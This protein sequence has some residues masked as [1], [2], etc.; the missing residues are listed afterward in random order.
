MIERMFQRSTARPGDTGLVNGMVTSAANYRAA[1]AGDLLAALAFLA[2][3]L[4]R[5]V[6]TRSL[7]GGVVLLGFV[8]FGF[9]E[10]AVHRWVLHG[11]SSPAR[12]GHAHHHAQPTALVSTPFFVIILA[13]LA[14]F[15]LLRFVCPA[16]PAAL[17]VFGLYAG[18]NYFA[19]F[20]HWEH[21]HRANMACGA[22]WRQ[23]DRLH[24][25]HHQR[26]GVNFGIS[27]TIWDRL[28][29][30]FQPTRGTATDSAAER[31][32]RAR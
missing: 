17:L 8:S 5:F 21:H 9:L 12:R 14:V 27:T 7:A 1:M 3:G 29:G 10:Y 30:T 22:Y 11:P 13:S 31:N 4:R 16:G 19:F 24:H 6:G 15:E 28:F 20:H 25:L 32:R 2:F 23:L 26:Q 18:Y